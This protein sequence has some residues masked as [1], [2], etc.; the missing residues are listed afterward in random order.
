MPQGI[1][2]KFSA[3]MKTPKRRPSVNTF[4]KE[5]QLN[6]TKFGLATPYAHTNKYKYFLL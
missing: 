5:A 3:L 1:H 2:G 6:I 4:P